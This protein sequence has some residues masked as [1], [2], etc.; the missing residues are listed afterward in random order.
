M[1]SMDTSA[2]SYLS[3]DPVNHADMLA[4]LN[5]PGVQ[6][7]YAKEDG[8]VLRYEG[9]CFISASNDAAALRLLPLIA[10]GP[11]VAAHNDALIAPLCSEHGYALMM[12]CYNHAYLRA[13]PPAYALPPG[14][15]IRPLTRSDLPAVIAH[16]HTVS[17]PEYAAERLDAGMFGVTVDGRLAGFI[18]THAE[19][20]M[21]MLEIFPAYRRMGLAHALEAHFIGQLLA[22]G[23]VPF[24]QVVA[25]NAPSLRLQEKLGM[26]IGNRI[27][28]WIE[29][30][31]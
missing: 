26:T 16:Y 4:V 6:V 10:D 21:G 20:S 29:R 18:G 24:G 8:V 19:R 3:A 25:D 27:M 30:A 11:C 9:I 5:E 14:A 1:T 17:S 22:Q 23:R 13:E 12:R 28:S 7:R 2:Y 15:A 31:K